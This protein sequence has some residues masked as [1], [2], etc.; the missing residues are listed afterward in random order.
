MVPTCVSGPR[1]FV[2]ADGQRGSI[3]TR[4][5]AL[6]PMIQAAPAEIAALKANLRMQA[7]ER[8]AVA[9]R[10]TGAQTA[11]QLSNYLPELYLPSRC[12]VAGYIQRGSELD[13]LPALKSLY[14]GGY[15][16]ALPV[17]TAKDAP[18]VFRAWAPDAQ[19]A[20]DV[21]GL[22]APLPTAPE[23]AP[24]ALFVPLIAFDGK[25]TRLGS[26]AGYYDRTLP[27]LR[28][29][30]PKLLV[31]GLAFAVQQERELPHEP[32]DA[33]LDAVITE[34]GVLWFRERTR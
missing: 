29:N 32:T 12:V 21:A 27:Q 5:R 1:G 19:L 9:Y 30:N 31:V 24:E 25:G 15:R 2:K 11:A 16:L 28:A 23:V 17:V 22:P 6:C 18:M 34:R 10:A 7:R 13:P 4:F 3:L 20:P 26:G 14:G 33:P 8:R